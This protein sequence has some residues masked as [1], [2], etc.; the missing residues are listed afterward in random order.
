MLETIDDLPVG[1]LGFNATGTVTE[2]DYRTVLIPAVESAAA[3]GDVRILYVLG[4]GYDGY[5]AGAMWEDVKVGFGDWS[6]W[7]RL[8]LVTDHRW[9]HD[10]AKAFTWAMPGEAKVFT[11]AELDEAKA[12]VAA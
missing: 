6:K 5:T 8:A 1:V 4:P 7:K 10:A 2:E 12:W 11:V 3:D 9:L